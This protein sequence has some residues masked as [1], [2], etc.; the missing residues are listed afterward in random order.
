LSRNSA[1][2]VR[3][4]LARDLLFELCRDAL[5]GWRHRR[6]DLADLDQGKAELALLRL[7]YIAGRQREGAVR[8]RGVHR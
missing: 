6:L 4:T 7:T 1:T 3:A 8:N 5:I 2:L